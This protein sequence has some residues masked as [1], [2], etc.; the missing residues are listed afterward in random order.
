M[1]IY[2]LDILKEDE[3]FVKENFPKSKIFLKRLN[4]KEIIKECK[5]AEV[6]CIS[7]KTKI[8]KNIISSLKNLKLIIT[9]SVGYDNIDIK[10][11]KERGIIVCNVPDYGSHVI[12][13]FVFGLLL[14]GL[15]NIEK[16]DKRVE[17]K[18]FSFVGLRGV[19][20][21]GKKLGIIGTG[22]IGMHVARIASLGFLMDVLAYDPS[23]DREKEKEL[24]FS[25]TKIEDIWKESDIIT[26]HCPL[27]ENTKH[28]INK[29]T[30]SLMKKG[31]IIVNTSRGGLIKTKDLVAS[32]K[33][34][35]VSYAFLDVLEHEN[36]IKLNKDL[37]EIPQVITTPHIAFYAD[38]SMKKMHEVSFETIRK[39]LNKEK[40]E[41]QVLGI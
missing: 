39:Y 12:S 27:F 30:L 40:L 9:R 14:S 3:S 36:N 33:S 28:L 32:I 16:G 7:F 1:N 15:R 5:D 20:L 25:Y 37:I 24:N 38:D 23:P 2:F 34:G 11:A 17:N 21:K 18:N 26:L 19:A 29:E 4:K 13:E 10:K 41:N 8:D 22:K 6:L 35:I 31:V